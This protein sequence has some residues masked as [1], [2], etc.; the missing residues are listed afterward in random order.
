MLDLQSPVIRWAR[1]TVSLL[2]VDLCN[3]SVAFHHV[4]RAVTKLRLEGKQ[5]STRTEVGDGE[6]MSKSVRVA[7]G[8]PS[9]FSKPFYQS[10]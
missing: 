10:S 6:R 3:P 2:D 9:S 7:V 5:I 1:T 8:Y 4:E